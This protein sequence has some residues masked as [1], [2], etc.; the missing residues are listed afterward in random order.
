METQQGIAAFTSVDLTDATLAHRQ[1]IRTSLAP[2]PPP[3]QLPIPII[4]LQKPFQMQV[5]APPP[6]PTRNANRAVGSMPTEPPTSLKIQ[7][8]SAA[9][10]DLEEGGTAKERPG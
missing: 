5:L 10:R 3:P 1:G 6:S 2:L 4:P 7:N 8:V 9:T